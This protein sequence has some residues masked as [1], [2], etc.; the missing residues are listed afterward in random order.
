MILTDNKKF[1]EKARKL[2]NLGFEKNK[3]FYHKELA[4][5]YRMTNLQAA[6]GL[7][8]LKNID[9]LIKIK[10]ENAKRYTQQLK[11]IKGLQLPIE[12]EWAKNVF[13]MYGIVLDR[14][15][16]YTAETFSQK[17]KEKGIDTRPFFYPLHLQPVWEKMKIKIKKEKYSV[18]EK[19]AEQG[20]YLP[21]GL[22]LK[23]K[24]I[25]RVC[26]T[27]KNILC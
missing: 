18:A 10:R 24:E 4:R 22:G 12:K 11:H 25:D 27:V 13:W 5:N 9:K 15:T 26:Q 20:L 1:A 8:Q 23:K 14:K 2:R 3:R 19:I 21:S 6:V 16:G 17:L 7:A